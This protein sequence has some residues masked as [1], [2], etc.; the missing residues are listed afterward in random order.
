MAIT[1]GNDTLVLHRLLV[2][3][4]EDKIFQGGVHWKHILAISSTFL[5][6]VVLKCLLDLEFMEKVIIAP[7]LTMECFLIVYLFSSKIVSTYFLHIKLYKLLLR[8]TFGIYLYADPLNYLILAVGFALF[9]KQLFT[10]MFLSIGLYFVRII[11]TITVSIALCC[12]IRKC[13]LKYLC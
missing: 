8:N 3:T 10:D 5:L 4:E 7:L 11:G 12:V 9:G 6:T 13:K 2:W 1:Y